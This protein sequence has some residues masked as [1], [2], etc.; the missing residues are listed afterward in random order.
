M[1][2]GRKELSLDAAEPAVIRRRSFLRQV[3][4]TVEPYIAK[5][6]A[7]SVD[8]PQEL[9]RA[10]DVVGVNVSDDEKFEV[11]VVRVQAVDAFLQRIVGRGNA[12]VNEYPARLCFVAIF[13][14][15]P[16]TIAR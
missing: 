4:P 14:P 8:A 2:E 6:Q 16:A 12:S 5:G 11:A 7:E 13:D 1:N 15:E 9:D 3:L 10:F